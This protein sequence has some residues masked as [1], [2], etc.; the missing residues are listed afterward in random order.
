MQTVD[1][2]S[3]LDA[4]LYP[5]LKSEP[6]SVDRHVSEV[7]QKLNNVLPEVRRA[8]ND[9]ESRI[10]TAEELIGKG[11]WLL[12]KVQRLGAASTR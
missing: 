10:K 3:K 8:Q 12:N 5:V 9:I 1:W 4:Q 2:V 7:K 11:W 6:S